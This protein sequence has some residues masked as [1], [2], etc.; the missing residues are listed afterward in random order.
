MLMI[1]M[2]NIK[3]SNFRLIFFGYK[4]GERSDSI[5]IHQAKH[6]EYS[7]RE[8]NAF[9]ESQVAGGTGVLIPVGAIGGGLIGGAVGAVGGAAAGL[10]GGAALGAAAVLSVP[11]AGYALSTTGAVIKSQSNGIDIP[12]GI[13]A[14]FDKTHQFIGE[15]ENTWGALPK[16]LLGL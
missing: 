2:Q 13:S 4:V 5:L 14:F 12:G 15:Q 9:E 10:V 16:Q 7:M 11:A 3:D 1:V 6:R 8:I